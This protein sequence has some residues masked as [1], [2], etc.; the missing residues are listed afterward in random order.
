MGS[1]EIPYVGYR[2][3]YAFIG[4]TGK[5]KCIEKRAGT[6]SEEVSIT[7]LVSLISG[8]EEIEPEKAKI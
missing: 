5:N 8:S 6:E 4:E 1:I 2:C 7:Q 3:G